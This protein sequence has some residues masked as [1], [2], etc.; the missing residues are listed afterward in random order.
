LPL[1]NSTNIK[2]ESVTIREMMNRR[3]PSWAKHFD[4][5][6]RTVQVGE[7]S[8]ERRGRKTAQVKA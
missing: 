2:D 1:A 6:F 4:P 5:G 3:S 7:V 8:G